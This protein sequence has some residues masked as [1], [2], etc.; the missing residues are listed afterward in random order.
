[1]FCVMKQSSATF[2]NDVSRKFYPLP[3]NLETQAH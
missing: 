2:Q 1:M 3:T